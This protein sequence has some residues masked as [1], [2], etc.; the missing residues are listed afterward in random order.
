M[1]DTVFTFYKN[2]NVI[3]DIVAKLYEKFL[4][5][6]QNEKEFEE[7]FKI[8]NGSLRIQEPFYEDLKSER[9]EIGEDIDWNNYNHIDQLTRKELHSK[10]FKFCEKYGIDSATFLKFYQCKM[11]RNNNSTCINL[12]SIQNSFHLQKR[13]ETIQSEFKL[14]DAIE[15]KIHISQDDFNKLI[16]AFKKGE[17]HYR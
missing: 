4:F 7:Y 12:P 5:E 10:I 14:N 15:E 2:I 1:A 3:G 11:D 8:K 17:I 6:N 9:S 16:E 13:L